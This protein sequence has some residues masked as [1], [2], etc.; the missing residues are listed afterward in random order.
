MPSKAHQHSTLE[1]LEFL[2]APTAIGPPFLH[3]YA[4]D[5]LVAARAA[6]ETDAS[7]FKP[8]RYF[9][10]CQSIELSLKAYLSLRGRKMV[11]MAQGA[12]GHHLDRL[13]ADALDEGLSDLVQ[14][15]GDD[16]DEIRRASDYY[17]SKVF[18][19]PALGEA[20]R[21]YPTLP[22]IDEL[23]RAAAALVDGLHESCRRGDSGRTE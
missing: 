14:L 21:G 16:L 9:L 4:A 12:M 19:Y 3:I 1:F 17:G 22:S 15:T 18:Q 7:R 6:N 2:G 5:Y 20:V 11:T 23:L 13:L 10:V 8:A